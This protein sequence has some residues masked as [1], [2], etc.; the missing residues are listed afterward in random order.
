[1][2]EKAR[3]LLVEFD[4][5]LRDR[6]AGTVR[7]WGYTVETA[8]DGRE[9]LEKVTAFDPAVII[10]DMRMPRMGGIELLRA[11]RNQLR[12]PRFIILADAWN[13]D[14]VFEATRLGALAVLHKPADAELIFADLRNCLDRPTLAAPCSDNTYAYCGDHIDPTCPRRGFSGTL[15]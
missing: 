1:M 5:D 8:R 3:V 11:I 7:S 6:L 4:T 10:S 14:R 15:N 9:A 2:E 13:P 12:D